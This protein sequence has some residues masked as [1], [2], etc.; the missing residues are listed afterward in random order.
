MGGLASA[1]NMPNSISHNGI[2][3]FNISYIECS[4]LSHAHGPQTVRVSPGRDR[5]YNILMH[6]HGS[7][8]EIRSYRIL[9]ELRLSH[10]LEKTKSTAT[11][12][13]IK[14]LISNESD[15][16]PPSH[17]F[18]KIVA[19]FNTPKNKIRDKA[20]RRVIQ[21]AWNYFPIYL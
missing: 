2:G 3:P 13:D 15:T 14:Q 10:F 7:D 18:A 12:D 9:T 5:E 17:Y 8:N 11:L 1:V 16:L 6:R 21:D 20:L 19:L 4:S